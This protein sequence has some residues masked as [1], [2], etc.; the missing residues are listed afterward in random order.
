MT[1]DEIRD[2]ILAKGHEVAVHGE[3][4]MAPGIAFP[5]LAIRDIQHCREALEEEFDI[6]VR[7]MAYPDS[8][9]TK[10]HNG[11]N[12]PMIR[13]YIKDLGI[14]YSRTLGADHNRFLLPEDFIAW[15]PNAH[16]K[17]PNLFKYAEEFVSIKE[18]GLYASRRYPNLFYLW[19][20]SYEFDNDDNWDL[21]ERFCETVGGK[22]DTWYA[23]NIEI[24]EYVMAYN[25]L[26][27]SA[28]GKKM[29]NPTLKKIWLDVDGKPYS[30]EPGET[31]V[32][33]N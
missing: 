32:F 29:Y 8:G 1:A 31:I 7:G 21:I 2:N 22:D 16:H 6:I 14:V 10:M 5:H 3:R 15:L 25:S 30:I 13:E 23:T 27:V 18:E 17:N 4:H 26:V 24:C 12:Y 19:G 33:D 11:N 9:I 28:N 20:H